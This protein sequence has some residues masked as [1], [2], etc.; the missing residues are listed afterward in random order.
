MK[1]KVLSLL[2]VGLLSVGVGVGVA[3]AAVKPEVQNDFRW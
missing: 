2:L 1:N 3:T